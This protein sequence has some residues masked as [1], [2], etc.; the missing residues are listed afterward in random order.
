MATVIKID[1][2]E[3]RALIEAYTGRYCFP[4]AIQFVL[5]GAGNYV[6]STENL[7]NE[8][9]LYPDSVALT[10]FLIENNVLQQFR[11]ILDVIAVYGTEIEY[12]PG[13]AVNN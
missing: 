4:D 5:D 1:D 6:M 13:E 12:V 9:Y 7:E 2:A 10:A 3:A 11:N 8:K